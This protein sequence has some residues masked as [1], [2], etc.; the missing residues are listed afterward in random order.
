MTIYQYHSISRNGQKRSGRIEAPSEQDARRLVTSSGDMLISLREAA[1]RRWWALEQKKL[2]N[3]RTASDFAL[4][5]AGLLRAGASLRQSLEIQEEGNTPSA[6]LA[7]SL[8]LQ[9]DHGHSLSSALKSGGGAA[10]LLGEFAAAGEAGAGLDRLLE[11]GGHFLNARH[12]AISRIRN[13]LAYPAFIMLL[14]I[15]ALVTITLVVAP[16]LAPVLEDSGEGGFILW[17]ANIGLWAQKRAEL[18]YLSAALMLSTGF[19]LLRTK[20]V[21]VGLEKLIW[22][23]PGIGSTARDIETGQSCEILSA[24][25]DAGRPLESSLRFAA[26]ISSPGVARAYNS[27]SRKIRDGTPAS[28][29]F[30]SEPSLPTEVR[31]LALLGEKASGLPDAL[32]QAGQICHTRAMRRIERFAALIGP[33]LV[34]GMGG[35]VALLM[36]NILGTISGIGDTPL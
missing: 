12:E 29:A 11:S 21:R 17:L 35:A 10:I 32:R 22:R 31:R 27:I 26:H 8:S 28:T 4:E 1:S 24:L 18:I 13:A 20:S 3:L 25:L 23:I 9:I 34:I 36:L 7:Q 30:L 19:L 6:K 15:M 16:A 14:G 5:L 2:I 33:I